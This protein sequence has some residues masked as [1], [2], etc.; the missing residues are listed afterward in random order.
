MMAWK[1]FSDEGCSLE[2]TEDLEAW[3]FSIKTLILG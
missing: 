1:I 3:F 2:L